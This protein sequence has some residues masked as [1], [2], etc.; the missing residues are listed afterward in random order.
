MSARSRA[1]RYLEAHGWRRQ[2]AHHWRRPGD[3]AFYSLDEA[4]TAQSVS[5]QQSCGTVGTTSED[6]PSRRALDSE[7]PGKPTNP[8]GVGASE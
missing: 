7:P 8:Q 2:Q 4:M 6:E 3:A 5:E 1:A